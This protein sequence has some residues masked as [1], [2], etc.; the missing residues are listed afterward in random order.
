MNVLYPA[1][2]TESLPRICEKLAAAFDL[3]PFRRIHLSQYLET[4]QSGEVFQITVTEFIA[5]VR[6]EQATQ[7][8][9]PDHWNLAWRAAVGL[10]FNYQVAIGRG[11]VTRSQQ[12]SIA[13]KLRSVFA[14]IRLHGDPVAPNKRGAGDGGNASQSQV[15]RTRP[16][17]PDHER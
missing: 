3:P 16:A 1:I 17:A 5:P 7:I 15:G 14:E 6:S 4:A 10:R 8:G 12:R 13:R 2:S 9:P 11:A